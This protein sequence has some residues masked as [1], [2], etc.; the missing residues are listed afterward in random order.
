MRVEAERLKERDVHHKEDHG[1]SQ[2]DT[3]RPRDALDGA[4]LVQMPGMKHTTSVTPVTSSRSD[5]WFD[6]A[7][8][9]LGDEADHQDGEGLEDS[10]LEP[11]AKHVGEIGLVG[12]VLGVDCGTHE[13]SGRQ[14]E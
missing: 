13:C 7:I 3:G 12:D 9:V 8:H 5:E 11:G 1:R 4:A 6:R 2:T 10:E 14:G